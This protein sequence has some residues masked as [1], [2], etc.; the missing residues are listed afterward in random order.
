MKPF[1][2]FSACSLPRLCSWLPEW[3]ATQA[4]MLRFVSTRWRLRGRYERRDEIRIAVVYFQT[5]K[6]SRKAFGKKYHIMSSLSSALNVSKVGFS[7]ILQYIVML[8]A[9][10][11]EDKLL[12]VLLPD[13]SV[14][15]NISYCGTA[16]SANISQKA[17]SQVNT[18]K[19]KLFTV[20][21]TDAVKTVLKWSNDVKHLVK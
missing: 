5:L 20:W 18:N 17:T 14:L 13:L 12:L 2:F 21:Y 8:Q 9:N 19:S 6:Q 4:H 3:K 15:Y 16:D 1:L 7:L 11:I 10:I